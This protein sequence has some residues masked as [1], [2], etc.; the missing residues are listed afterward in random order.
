ML[1]SHMVP[2]TAIVLI[3]LPA[4]L[5]RNGHAEVR[6]LDVTP[7]VAAITELTPAHRALELARVL[8]AGEDDVLVNG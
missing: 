2:Q 1:A 4:V 5:T 7:R 3:M 6:A 8:R